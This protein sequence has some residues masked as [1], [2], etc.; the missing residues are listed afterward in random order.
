MIVILLR[1]FSAK[2]G[3]CNGTRIIVTN[4]QLNYIVGKIASG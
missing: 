2:K 3:L 1:N 4:V